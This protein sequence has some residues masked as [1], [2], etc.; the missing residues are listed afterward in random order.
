MSVII[1]GLIIVFMIAVF[2]VPYWLALRMKDPH[3]NSVLVVCLSLGWTIL[4]WFLA[5][6]FVLRGR[7]SQEDKET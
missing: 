7:E 4:F 3:R 1:E 2:L 6:A 5:L